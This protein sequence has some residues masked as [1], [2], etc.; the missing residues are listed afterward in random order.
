MPKLLGGA[1]G[2]VGTAMIYI[3]EI[4]ETEGSLSLVASKCSFSNTREHEYGCFSIVAYHSIERREPKEGQ[5]PRS[6]PVSPCRRLPREPK[7][8]IPIHFSFYPAGV[9][10]QEMPPSWLY[11]V[12]IHLHA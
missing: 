9:R 6:L 8:D 11:G 2:E 7:L 3:L 10:L 5:L 1:S 4:N 12:Y